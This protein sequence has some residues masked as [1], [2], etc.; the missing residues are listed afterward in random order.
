M[1]H[2]FDRPD[3]S[4]FSFRAERCLQRLRLLRCFL[5][6]RRDR[7]SASAAAGCWRRVQVHVLL[8]QAKE[9]ARSAWAKGFSN[10]LIVLRRLGELPA[11]ASQRVEQLK[12]SGY[13]EAQLYDSTAAS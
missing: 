12:Q 2:R 5:P 4:R 1:S 7:S 13:A 9:W 10:E 11:G 8:R 6:I 3:R